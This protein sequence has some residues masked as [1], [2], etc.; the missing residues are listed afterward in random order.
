VRQVSR[1]FVRRLGG[2]KQVRYRDTRPLG[3]RP[4]SHRHVQLMNSLQSVHDRFGRRAHCSSRRPVT[5]S[6]RHW[7]ESTTMNLIWGFQHPNIPSFKTATHPPCVPFSSLCA[8]VRRSLN[9]EHRQ[10]DNARA[11]ESGIDNDRCDGHVCSRLI[12]KV[13]PYTCDYIKPK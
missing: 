8:Y 9:V 6:H 2:G 10:H 5:M 1:P 12:L 4:P 11:G 7:L 3:R 13:P